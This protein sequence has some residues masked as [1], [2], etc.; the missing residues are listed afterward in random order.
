LLL[1]SQAR[2]VSLLQAADLW[3]LALAQARELVT[4]WLERC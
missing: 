2:A 1:Q 4:P 3:P